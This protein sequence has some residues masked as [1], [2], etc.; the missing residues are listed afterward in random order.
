MIITV[1]SV[2][3]LAP[4]KQML[5]LAPSASS[6]PSSAEKVLQ[7]RCNALLSQL[8]DA[9]PPGWKTKCNERGRQ[10][11]Y[12]TGT[13]ET[14]WKRPAGP[15]FVDGDH[16]VA[17]LLKQWGDGGEEWG[18]ALG[19]APAAWCAPATPEPPVLGGARG[20]E[21]ASQT[22]ALR[23]LRNSWS[24]AAPPLRGLQRR[25]AK[26]LDKV[27]G[28]VERAI[29]A[30]EGVD[31]KEIADT[32]RQVNA[33]ATRAGRQ[34]TVSALLANLD[35]RDVAHCKAAASLCAETD[36]LTLRDVAG[37]V[38]SER[39]AA[40]RLKLKTV[41]LTQLD[42][43][44][45]KREQILAAQRPEIAAAFAP[46]TSAL[47]REVEARCHAA[48]AGREAAE[49]DQVKL[50]DLQVSSLLCTVTF[51]ANLAHSLTRSPSHL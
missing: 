18:V 13:K 35:A 24:G 28:I 43:N 10:Y 36:A 4:S 31:A 27:V 2:E 34:A 40:V 17:T 39:V 30:H 3:D 23:K 48:S 5:V 12:R 6:A 11:Y 22:P 14:Q 19:I 1:T 41:L 49:N 47:R 45:R 38:P 26:E 46:P 42:V 33:W 9:L 29:K 8:T 37:D 51:Y 21:A 15:P 44:A 20:A 32:V 7:Q 16:A 25:S 50:S